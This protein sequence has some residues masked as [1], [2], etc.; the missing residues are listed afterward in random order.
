MESLGSDR[1]VRDGLTWRPE[2]QIGGVWDFTDREGQARQYRDGN[3]MN[4][5][6]RHAWPWQTTTGLESP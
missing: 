1:L 5:L 6:P 2:Q 3:A 4:G